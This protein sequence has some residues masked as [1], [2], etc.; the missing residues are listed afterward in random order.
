MYSVGTYVEIICLFLSSSS[1]RSGI[2]SLKC[3]SQQESLS[4]LQWSN[5]SVWQPPPLR[6]IYNMGVVL[7]NNFWPS[8]SINCLNFW[9]LDQKII[10][11]T[12]VDNCITHS[13]T[14]TQV[15]DSDS[16]NMEEDIGSDEV[17]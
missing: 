6:Y 5:C 4:P 17:P 7:S 10:P 1:P 2:L 13:I 3:V 15:Q 11:E 9:S 8:C 12:S 14:C 16:D